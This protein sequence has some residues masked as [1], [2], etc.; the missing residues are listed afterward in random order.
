VEKENTNYMKEAKNQA[1]V[2]SIAELP[3]QLF[4]VLLPTLVIVIQMEVEKG[5]TRLLCNN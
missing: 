5:N 2:V 1:T 4:L 3:H